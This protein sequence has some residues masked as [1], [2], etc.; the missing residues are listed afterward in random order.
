MK[1]IFEHNGGT[2][3]KVGKYYIPNVLVPDTKKYTIGK[4][5]RMHAKF[6][7]QNRPCIYSVKMLNGTWLEYLQER[8][9][10]AKEMVDKI[11]K[12]LATEQGITEELK[13]KDQFAWVSAMENIKHSAEAF[14]LNEYVYTL[15]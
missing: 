3:I 6:I 15:K 12:D 11:I 8:D 7:K 5:G 1:S 2:Y 13:A 14:I 10:D 9:N 4:Y